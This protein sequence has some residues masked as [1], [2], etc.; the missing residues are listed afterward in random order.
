LPGNINLTLG[1]LSSAHGQEV[2]ARL[3]DEIIKSYPDEDPWHAC[4]VEEK[5]EFLV[6][7]VKVRHQ[8]QYA[9]ASNSQATGSASILVHPEPFVC[10]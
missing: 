7:F 2:Q 9:P 4:L 6:S 8:A 1:Y 3:Y 10:P 5:S